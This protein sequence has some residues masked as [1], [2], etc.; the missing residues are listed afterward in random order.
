MA[1]LKEI[2]ILISEICQIGLPVIQQTPNILL[3]VVIVVQPAPIIDQK[4]KGRELVDN[5][6][7]G[8]KDDVTEEMA[9][10]LLI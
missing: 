1:S 4:K 10:D 6:G 9:V 2:R 5:V 3:H 7:T 8:V